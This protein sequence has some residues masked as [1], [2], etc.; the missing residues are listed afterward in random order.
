MSNV[1]INFVI[2]Y[3]KIKKNNNK[4]TTTT[5]TNE[6][7]KQAQEI[8]KQNKTKQHENKRTETSLK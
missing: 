1:T 5:K 3:V 2:S 8:N 4:T 6:H 7:P